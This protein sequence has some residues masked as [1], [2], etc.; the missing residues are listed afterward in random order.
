MA[1]ILASFQIEDQRIHTKFKVYK[2]VIAGRV[3]WYIP[4]YQRVCSGKRQS[5]SE[6]IRAFYLEQLH[7]GGLNHLV[8]GIRELGFSAIPKSC[9]HI[10][11]KAEGSIPDGLE[12]AG[13]IGVNYYLPASSAIRS[14]ALA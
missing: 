7:K 4:A 2:K 6:V 5:A 13:E 9:R 14:M 12:L 1:E 10:R 11:M 3:F 8:K